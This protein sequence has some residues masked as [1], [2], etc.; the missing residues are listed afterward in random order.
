MMM[1]E[2]VQNIFKKKSVNYAPV[3]DGKKS[4]RRRFFSNKKKKPIKITSEKYPEETSTVAVSHISGPPSPPRRHPDDPIDMDISTSL[5]N[6]TRNSSFEEDSDDEQQFIFTSGSYEWEDQEPKHSLLKTL[7]LADHDARPN[8]Y[9]IAPK[10]TLKG[11]SSPRLASKSQ[12]V[13]S[14]A[15]S[16]VNKS[17]TKT[18]LPKQ[19]TEKRIQNRRSLPIDLDTCEVWEGDP[20]VSFVQDR[21]DV[22]AWDGK[23]EPIDWNYNTTTETEEAGELPPL[24]S[25]WSDDFM[26]RD[27]SDE[28]SLDPSTASLP[29]MMLSS[30]LEGEQEIVFFS[31]PEC[32]SQFLANAGDSDSEDDQVQDVPGY[33]GGEEDETYSSPRTVMDMF[34]TVCTG[35]SS[36]HPKKQQGM[37]STNLAKKLHQETLTLIG[38]MSEKLWTLDT[39]TRARFQNGI[40]KQDEKDEDNDSITTSGSEET[41]KKTNLSLCSSFEDDFIYTQGRPSCHFFDPFFRTGEAEI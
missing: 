5:I 18:A 14:P 35:Q 9:N 6:T 25:L 24:S 40:W 13:S 8:A 27:T 38:S 21:K 19:D 33:P 7:N 22:L 23:K 41:V 32:P 17:T 28:A 31:D 12:T 4:S 39:Q 2:R 30:D 16:I 20:W 11:P 1:T 36:Q 3:K 15:P 10:T 29:V 26:L 37:G 34:D